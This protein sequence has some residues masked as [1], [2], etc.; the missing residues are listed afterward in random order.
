M[1]TPEQSFYLRSSFVFAYGTTP[2]EAMRAHAILAQFD[3]NA[4]LLTSRDQAWHYKQKFGF[5]YADLDSSDPVQASL[6]E[7]GKTRDR[8]IE[9]LARTSPV[10]HFIEPSGYLLIAIGAIAGSIGSGFGQEIGKDLWTL[11]KS[12]W[13]ILK[14]NI[15]SFRRRLRHEKKQG[16]VEEKEIVSAKQRSLA[17]L[18]DNL[19]TL[20]N[21]KTEWNPVIVLQI[22]QEHVTF[23]IEPR[24]PRQA[25]E[26]AERLITSSRSKLNV[27]LRWHRD[28]KQWLSIEKSLDNEQSLLE[29]RQDI[30][31]VLRGGQ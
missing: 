11:T 29:L 4:A 17:E 6:K 26:Q 8:R 7:F 12:K 2:A 21:P 20:Y 22:R 19:S 25:I 24:V 13:R 23:V 31:K 30:N 27:P 28:A 10:H 15:S 14:S 3:E 18:F 16:Q 1:D 9:V 5:H